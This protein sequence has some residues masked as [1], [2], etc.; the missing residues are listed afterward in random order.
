M[1]RPILVAVSARDRDVRG[2]RPRGRARRAVVDLVGAHALAQ[3]ALQGAED[4]GEVL[5]QRVVGLVG[6]G[7]Q[8]HL[9]A[10]LAV[11]ALEHQ[12]GPQRDAEDLDPDVVVLRLARL[13]GRERR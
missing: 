12:V 13:L 5:G 8:P 11:V 3:L 10:Q 9:A 4:V 2:R 1:N 7:E 6:Q